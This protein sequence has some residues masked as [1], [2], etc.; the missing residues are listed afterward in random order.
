LFDYTVAVRDLKTSCISPA[1]HGAWYALPSER[2]ALRRRWARA[3]SGL[4]ETP[5]SSAASGDVA[6]AWA[7]TRQIGLAQNG[8]RQQIVNLRQGIA[9]SAIVSSR[10]LS[11]R[12][13]LKRKVAV[14]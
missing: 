10:G 6:H 3:I 12:R 2:A 5:G 4:S 7:L 9:R 13:A 11:A 8:W 1:F 14:D